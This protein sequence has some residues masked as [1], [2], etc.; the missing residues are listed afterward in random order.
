MKPI[1]FDPAGWMYAL[2]AA[3]RGD[4]NVSSGTFVPPEAVPFT[5]K[6]STN[7]FDEN[8]ILEVYH[9][10]DNAE[11]EDEPTFLIVGKLKDGRFFSVRSWHDYSGWD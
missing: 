11:V 3:L 7:T 2:N 6:V 8:D 4:Y 5:S 9:A 10:A 1:E